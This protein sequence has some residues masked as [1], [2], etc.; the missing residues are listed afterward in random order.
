M[1]LHKL[2]SFSH[3]LVEYIRG[4]ILSFQI[5]S[6]QQIYEA[7]KKENK[8]SRNMKNFA[9]LAIL[10]I[11]MIVMMEQFNWVSWKIESVKKFL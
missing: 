11:A 5:I 4:T 3:C 9:W 6:N 1:K 8:N 10:V 7:S 2:H